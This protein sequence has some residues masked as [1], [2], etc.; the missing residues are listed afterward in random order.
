M[1]FSRT[2]VD[3]QDRRKSR[4]K[5]RNPNSLMNLHNNQAGRKVQ[6]FYHKIL[7]CFFYQMLIYL[8]SMILRVSEFFRYF[9]ARA[10]FFLASVNFWLHFSYIYDVFYP[11]KIMELIQSRKNY[12]L[13]NYTRTIN[14][15]PLCWSWGVGA[16]GGG[17]GV[18]A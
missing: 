15:L 4:K 13:Y 7:L 1:T 2:F 5:P 17:G 10:Y 14:A 12:G 8:V 18:C 6:N 11:E 16:G 3:A 9:F